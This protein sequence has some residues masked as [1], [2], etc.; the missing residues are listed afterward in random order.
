MNN[1]DQLV[2]Q[3]TR[4]VYNLPQK[5]S[6]TTKQGIVHAFTVWPIGATDFTYHVQQ[7]QGGGHRGGQ[8][9]QFLMGWI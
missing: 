7:Q 3:L 4:T 9:Q 2:G 8:I 6:I 5:L 1:K